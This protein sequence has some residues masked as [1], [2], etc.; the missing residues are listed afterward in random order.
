MNKLDLRKKHDCKD[1][2]KIINEL[3]EENNQLHKELKKKVD[4]YEYIRDV[5]MYS[6]NN[7]L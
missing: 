3:I 5:T 6:I 2:A 1:L 7:R 4:Y